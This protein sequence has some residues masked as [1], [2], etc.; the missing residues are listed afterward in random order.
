MITTTALVAVVFFQPAMLFSLAGEEFRVM[1][2]GVKGAEILVW[3]DSTAES[4]EVITSMLSVCVAIVVGAA[5]LLPLVTLFLYK[6]RLVQIRLLSA[7][8]VL[9]VGSIGF[10]GFYLWNAYSHIV[11]LLGEGYILSPVPLLLVVALLTNWFAIR[12]IASDEALVR[13]ADRIR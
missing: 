6:K 12:R 4:G 1:T 3:G 2:Y 7:E 5:A 13:S 8:F 11:E 10:L 9:L